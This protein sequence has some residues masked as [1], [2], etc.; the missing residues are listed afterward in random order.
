MIT[1]WNL[2]IVLHRS[3]I[4]LCGKKCTFYAQEL[5]NYQCVSYTMIDV[6]FQIQMVYLATFTDEGTEWNCMRL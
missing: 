2:N 5:V 6:A 3:I 4:H 1:H